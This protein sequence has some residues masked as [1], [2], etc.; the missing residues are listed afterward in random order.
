MASST[1]TCTQNLF[2]D[3]IERTLAAFDTFQEG[4]WDGVLHQL[5]SD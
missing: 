1:A 2:E 5:I 3:T 4:I